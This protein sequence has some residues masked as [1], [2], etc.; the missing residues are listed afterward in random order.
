MTWGGARGAGYRTS[1]QHEELIASAIVT[2]VYTNR[3]KAIE[4]RL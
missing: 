1:A 4:V 3:G 2:V